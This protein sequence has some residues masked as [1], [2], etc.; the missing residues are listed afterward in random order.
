MSIYAEKMLMDHFY[1]RVVLPLT[2]RHIFNGLP[3]FSS[4][5]KRTTGQSWNATGLAHL[6]M[7]EVPTEVNRLSVEAGNGPPW[8][9]DE[10][11]STPV[12]TPLNTIL[13]ALV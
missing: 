13:P 10:H 8:F 9:I 4:E 1:S 11:T 6:F 3:G 5:G 7:D 2:D 12:G